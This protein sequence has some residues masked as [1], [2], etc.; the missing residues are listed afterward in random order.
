MD[1]G[2]NLGM[3]NP[4]MKPDEQL[5]EWR[6]TLAAAGEAGFTFVSGL[7]QWLSHPFQFLSPLPTLAWMAGQ[8]PDFHYA[9]G[10]LQLPVLNP[11]QLAED[12]MTADYLTGGKFIL[13]VG[14]G[15]R[16][17]L[18]QAAGAD[19]ADRVARF[20]EAVVLMRALWTDGEVHHDGRFFQCHG[21][22]ARRPMTEP[23]VVVGAQSRGAA[24][25][26]GRLGDGWYI[27][28]QVAEPDLAELFPVYLEARRAAGKS[29]AGT[30]VLTRNVCVAPTDQEAVDHARTFMGDTFGAYRT[31]GLEESTTVRVHR[32]FDEE[33]SQRAVVGSVDTCRDRLRAL[34]D[35]FPVS[36]LQLRP[37]GPGFQATEAGLRDALGLLGE[38]VL[39]A[40]A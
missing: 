19:R 29:G 40:L 16:P 5:A 38:H 34:C 36:H 15:Y 33:I 27:P 12:V 4:G 14:L 3:P 22:L 11:V 24:E 18:F 2:I 8:F 26:A 35:R 13:G 37:Q 21:T 7:H 39:P 10:V 25:R 17:E 1:F 20:E 6:R 23:P 28:S 30:V 9:T 31:W 32:T